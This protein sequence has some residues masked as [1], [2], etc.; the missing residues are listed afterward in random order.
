L[1]SGPAHPIAIAAAKPHANTMNTVLR[2]M[3][4]SLR[5]PVCG[6]DTSLLS[7]RRS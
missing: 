2:N 1:P 4:P 7:A 6:P 5:I 3:L